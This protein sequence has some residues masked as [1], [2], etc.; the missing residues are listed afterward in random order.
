[1]FSLFR[2]GYH[3]ATLQTF[4]LA[5]DDIVSN[6]LSTQ[7]LLFGIDPEARNMELVEAAIRHE[8]VYFTSLLLLGSKRFSTVTA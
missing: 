4:N 8:H 2:F 6:F 1:M 5:K 3:A 7:Q